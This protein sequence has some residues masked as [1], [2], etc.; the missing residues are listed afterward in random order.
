MARARHEA[1]WTHA[2][3]T[4]KGSTQGN[5]PWVLILCVALIV[6]L[7]T[8]G[9]SRFWNLQTVSY[10]LRECAQPLTDESTWEQVQAAGCDPVDPGQTKLW[11]TNEGEQIEPATVEGSTFSFDMIPIHS[12]A[13]GLRVELDGAAQS[14]VIAEP[15]NQKIRRQM[16]GDRAGTSWSANI[17]SRGPLHYWVLVTP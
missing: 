6:G 15:E 9:Y 14:I 17:G 3:A 8:L 11:V 1:S 4:V 16:N 13:P 5:R 7:A 2:E 10:E 12:P